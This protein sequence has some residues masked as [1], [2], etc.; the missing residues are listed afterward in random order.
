[1]QSRDELL[2]MTTD[3]FLQWMDEL[4]AWGGCCLLENGRPAFHK[5]YTYDLQQIR[6]TDYRAL[7]QRDPQ[8]AW[9]VLRQIL[10]H[11]NAL[12]EDRKRLIERLVLFTLYTPERN[13]IFREAWEAN[14][15]LDLLGW[16]EMPPS[17][18]I[19]YYRALKDYYGDDNEETRPLWFDIGYGASPEIE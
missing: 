14:R 11:P 12:D 1:M 15:F 5:D 10:D 4:F 9:E 3:E 13:R 2:L 8:R 19:R 17:E 7:A 6:L 16:L 18:V